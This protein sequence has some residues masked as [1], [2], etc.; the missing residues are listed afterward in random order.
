LVKI[1]W[2]SKTKHYTAFPFLGKI[3]KGGIMKDFLVIAGTITIAIDGFFG[4][5]I[6]I[7]ASL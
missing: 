2:F 7:L 3:Y 5:L 1:S 4:S 6:G